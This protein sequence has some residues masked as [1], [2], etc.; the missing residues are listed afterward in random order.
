MTSAYAT[1]NID[2]TNPLIEIISESVCYLDV[3]K[4]EPFESDLENAIVDRRKENVLNKAF[5]E[6][7]YLTV[8]ENTKFILVSWDA[9]RPGLWYGIEIFGTRQQ[10]KTMT[11]NW[12]NGIGRGKKITE[13]STISYDNVQGIGSKLYF[14]SLYSHRPYYCEIL[15]MGSFNSCMLELKRFEERTLHFPLVP[16]DF[17]LSHDNLDLL[18]G[19][20]QHKSCRS[21]PIRIYLAI[22]RALLT[23]DKLN[24]EKE[25]LANLIQQKRAEIFVCK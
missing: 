25:I 10:F 2:T 8:N 17:L 21:Q 15:A 20:H 7:E 24:N 11:S 23:M 9:G 19:P 4:F 16:E 22:E 1:A 12:S 3:I 18:K 14:E 5:I 6:P 13:Y